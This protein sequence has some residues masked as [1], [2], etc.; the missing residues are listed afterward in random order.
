MVLSSYQ[1]PTSVYLTGDRT[2]HDSWWNERSLIEQA[3]DCDDDKTVLYIKNLD[4]TAT[5]AD[6]IIDRIQV[7]RQ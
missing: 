4:V 5:L 2:N 1:G 3:F 7:F 6:H